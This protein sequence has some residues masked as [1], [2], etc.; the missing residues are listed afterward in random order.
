[1]AARCYHARVRVV[2]VF[3]AVACVVGACSLDWSDPGAGT[4]GSGSGGGGGAGGAIGGSGGAGTRAVCGNGFIEA[5]EECDDQNELVDDFCHECLV[6]CEGEGRV[7]GPINHHCYG[8]TPTAGTWHEAEALCESLDAHLA[9]ISGPDELGV[10]S[11]IVNGDKA[12]PK[13]R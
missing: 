3:A 1:M 5:G 9:A 11:M 6:V 10:V 8:R 4:G 2:L 12:A 13:R 7:K